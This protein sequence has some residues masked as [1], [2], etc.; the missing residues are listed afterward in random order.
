MEWS[1]NVSRQTPRYFN[2]ITRLICPSRENLPFYRRMKAN[3]EKAKR[4][5]RYKRNVLV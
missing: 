1:V 3:K 4:R 2:A 5:V